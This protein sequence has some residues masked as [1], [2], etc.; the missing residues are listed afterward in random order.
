MTAAAAAHRS[1]RREAILAAALECFT[2]LGFAAATIDD[3][4]RRSG[5]S[6]GS[7]YHHFG[8][9]EQLAA[10]LYVDG[11]RGYQRGVLDA[12][13]RARDARS[14]IRALVAHHLRWVEGDPSLARFLANR[15]E[16]ELRLATEGRVREL[17][18]AFMPR[19]GAW[20]A[21]EVEAG[22]LR[23]LPRDLWEP[24]LLGPSQELGRLWLAG[25]TEISLRRAE[26]EL[27]ET[28]WRAV[29]G[30]DR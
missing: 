26:R 7:I 14:A 13:E 16:T 11:L 1:P 2:E 3:I 5:A 15:R 20:I 30:D 12:L 8:G 25:R 19:V 24:V 17:N 9:K 28:T 18:R 27:A 22:A 6:T 23:P 10:T 21:R 4:R 29:R